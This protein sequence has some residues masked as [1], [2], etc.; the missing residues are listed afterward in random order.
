MQPP[1][2]ILPLFSNAIA[3][4]LEVV[5]SL[6]AQG[7]LLESI[8]RRLTATVE[9]GK[10]ILWCGNGGSAADAQHLAAELIGRF[11]RERRAIPSIALTTDTSIL[12]SVGNDYGFE[13]I[14]RRQVEALA[15]PGDALVGLSTSGT[16]KN[17]CAAIEKAR[18]L[19]AFTIAMTGSGGGRA[20]QLAD[21]AICIESNDT[22][23]IQEAH[24]L[25]G[26]M[27]CDWIEQHAC[28]PQAAEAGSL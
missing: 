21:T 14:F 4:H 20:A 10:K 12:T 9:A 1:T 13:G 2:G 23:R 5:S 6:Q 22:A 11:R 7:E 17:V 27:L 16:S 15:G 19:G 26:H 3:E 8:A 25:V 18:A 28:S 24:I